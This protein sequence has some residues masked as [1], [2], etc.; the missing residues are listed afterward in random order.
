M[1]STPINT[2]QSEIEVRLKAL[3]LAQIHF[4]RYQRESQAPSLEDP[5]IPE[6]TLKAIEDALQN[7]YPPAIKHIDIFDA[8]TVNFTVSPFDADKGLSVKIDYTE[9]ADNKLNASI[10]GTRRQMWTLYTKLGAELV[11][12]NQ[13]KGDAGCAEVKMEEGPS[14]SRSIVTAI[15]WVSIVSAVIVWGIQP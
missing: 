2:P 10:V 4:N 3:K 12:G 5:F 11:R 1:L 15:G 13:R 9:I 8:Q 7:H 14:F 6:W